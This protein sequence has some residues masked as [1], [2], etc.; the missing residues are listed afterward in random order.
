MPQPQLTFIQTA[1]EHGI[2]QNPEAAAREVPEIGGHY[3][4]DNTR[5]NRVYQAACRVL[6]QPDGYN[7]DQLCRAVADASAPQITLWDDGLR[8]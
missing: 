1:I 3:I 6:I 2:R 8:P 7:M 5:L 4:L